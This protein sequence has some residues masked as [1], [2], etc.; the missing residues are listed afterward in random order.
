MNISETDICILVFPEAFEYF[1]DVS[2]GSKILIP[3]L[4]IVKPSTSALI[5]VLLPFKTSLQ[6]KITSNVSQSRIIN[7]FKENYWKKKK[8]CL[9]FI[10][11]K[12]IV[13]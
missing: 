13:L 11:S 4:S 6:L 3:L 9:F 7:F 12:I 1:N 2:N 10:R 5:S 8:A